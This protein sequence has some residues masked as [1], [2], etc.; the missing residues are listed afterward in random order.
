MYLC[1]LVF[2]GYMPRSGIA[3]LFGN[4]MLS[5]FQGPSVLFSTVAV[6]IYLLTDSV[7]RVPFPPHPLQPLSCVDFV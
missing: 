6:P 2:S 1:E 7:G 4:S 3:G 5:F